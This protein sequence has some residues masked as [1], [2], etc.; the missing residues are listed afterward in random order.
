MLID[1]THRP[2]FLFT[3][4]ALGVSSVA[5]AI[6]RFSSVQGPGGGTVMGLILVSLGWR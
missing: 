3:V 4:V 1:K 2:W 5:Y 6:Y